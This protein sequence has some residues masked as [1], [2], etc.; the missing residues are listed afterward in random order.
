[1]WPLLQQALLELCADRQ[2]IAQAQQHLQA[3]AMHGQ[4]LTVVPRLK[5]ALLHGWPTNAYRLQLWPALLQAIQQESREQIARSL[6]RHHGHAQQMR[7]Q[8]RHN[9]F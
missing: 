2:N 8:I 4:A 7:C 6:T 3:I 9:V 5:T 1:M